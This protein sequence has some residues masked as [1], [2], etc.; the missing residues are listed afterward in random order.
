[1]LR[2]GCGGDVAAPCAAT[3]QAAEFED[4]LEPAFA[5]PEELEEPFSAVFVEAP[6]DEDVVL[7]P[8]DCVVAADSERVSDFPL[9]PAEAAARESVR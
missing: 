9:D 3:G 8:S 2:A 7:A 1:M 6:S 5:A 4:E